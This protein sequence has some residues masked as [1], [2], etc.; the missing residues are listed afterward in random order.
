MENVKPISLPSRKRRMAA[1]RKLGVA[2]V[3][4]A[5]QF[6]ISKQRVGQILG[7]RKPNGKANG[8]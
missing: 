8:G 5:Q 6:G 1:L 3:A 2:D 4:I 7:P